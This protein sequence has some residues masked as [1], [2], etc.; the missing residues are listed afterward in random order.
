MLVELPRPIF[1]AAIERLSVLSESGKIKV[2]A[3]THFRLETVAEGLLL[4]TYNRTMRAEIL[5]SEVTHGGFQ[6]VCGIPLLDVKDLCATLPSA[7]SITLHFE[8]SACTFRCGTVRFKTRILTED[9]FPKPE[10]QPFEMK[11]VNLQTLFQGLSLV[12]HCT[13]ST[14][15]RQYAHGILI[16]KSGLCATDGMRLSRVPD[17]W[18]K[19]EKPTAIMMDT[20]TRFQKLFK[21]YTEGGIAI[22]E[23]EIFMTGGGIK[24]VARLA[25]WRFPS[26]EAAIPKP[27]GRFVEISKEEL[28]L[29]LERALIVAEEAV[30]L[31]LTTLQYTEEGLRIHTE[32]EGQVADDLVIAQCPGRATAYVNPRYLLEAVRS[33]EADS[34]LLDM[35]G[36]E[37]PLLLTEEGGAHVNVVMPLQ[38]PQ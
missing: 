37:I 10:P 9:A 16:T 18:I 34:I 27:S 3:Y 26:V 30:P 17:L 21:G 1:K 31:P 5:I 7:A 22:H 8:G 13:D 38:P 4:S 32:H 11:P 36:P 2:D 20:V 25:A 6:F 15:Q 12:Q 19:P 28:S 35:Q 24:A 33:F 23:G 14:S 29:A